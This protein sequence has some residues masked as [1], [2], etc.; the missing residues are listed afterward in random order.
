MWEENT[1]KLRRQRRVLE[2]VASRAR[3]LYADVRAFD[4][5]LNCTAR[6]SVVDISEAKYLFPL[7]T[8]YSYVTCV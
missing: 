1:R 8:I 7:D 3:P 4:L 5:S 6:V 2:K